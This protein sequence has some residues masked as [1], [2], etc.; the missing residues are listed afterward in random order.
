[1]ASYASNSYENTTPSLVFTGDTEYLKELDFFI[2][3]I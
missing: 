2:L 1:M 3:F